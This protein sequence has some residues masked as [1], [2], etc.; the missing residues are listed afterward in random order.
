MNNTEYPLASLFVNSKNNKKWFL[1]SIIAIILG[2]I[3]TFINFQ[4]VD[5]ISELKKSGLSSTQLEN[6]KKV[7]T[8]STYIG[9]VFTTIFTIIGFFL[10]FLVISRIMKSEVKK[11]SLFSASAIFV[12][13]NIIVNLIVLIIQWIFGLSPKKVI[14]TSLNIFDQGNQLLAIFDLKLIIKSYLFFLVLYYTSNLRKKESLIWTIAYLVI[15]L[16]FSL[17][18]YFVNK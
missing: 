13:L 7:M 3:A 14:L 17:I 11:K 8:F 6:A 12:L 15:V 9:N 18:S 5:L 2:V 10:I 4:L 16:L 1:S